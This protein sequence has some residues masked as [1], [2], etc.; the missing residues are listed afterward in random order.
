VV[1]QQDSIAW[2]VAQQVEHQDRSATWSQDWFGKFVEFLYSHESLAGLDDAVVE[3]AL[4]YISARLG[5]PGDLAMVESNIKSKC[6]LGI[7]R[8]CE[9]AVRGRSA[10][11]NAV[12]MFWEAPVLH[13]TSD[14]ELREL[15]LQALRAQLESPDGRCQESAIHGLREFHAPDADSVVQG[16]AHRPDRDPAA[17]ALARAAN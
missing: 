2:F 5:F 1:D 8:L 9:S 3:S 15:C 6:I 10:W 11:L 4:Y 7:P 13:L 17:R 14:P 12:F 16:F